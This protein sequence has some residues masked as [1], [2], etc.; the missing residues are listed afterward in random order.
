MKMTKRFIGFARVSSREQERE[1]FSLDVQEEAFEFFAKREKGVVDKVFRIAETATKTEQRKIFR[2]AIEFAKTNAA[3]YDGMLFYKIDRAARNIKDLILLEDIEEKYGLPFISVTQ[4]VENTPTGRMIRRTLATMGA[5]QTEQQ[6][7]D[8][9]SGIAKRV[10]LGWFPSRCPY[11]YRNVRHDDRATAEVHPENALKVRRAFELRAYEGMLVEQIIERLYEDGLFYAE[12]KPR[13]PETK[14]YAILHDLSY[15]GFVR[16]QGKW[17]P[18]L[19]EP[20]IDKLTWDLVRVSFGEQRYRSHELVYANLLIRCGYCGHPITGEE[21]A[22]ETKTGTKKYRYYR[23]ARYQCPGHPRI[24]VRESELDTQVRQSLGKFKAE[25]LEWQQLMLSIA[26]FRLDHERANSEIKAEE[27]KR[28]LSLIEGQRDELLNL[29]LAKVIAEDKFNA[30]QGEL[31]EREALIRHQVQIVDEQRN[32]DN[33]LAERAPGVFEQIRQDWDALRF[34]A[35]QDILRLLFGG[36]LLDG[37]TL[38]PDNE[39]PFELFSATQPSA[40][41]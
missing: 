38:V 37:R 33:A 10:A 36:F 32:R 6:S 17:H 3:K 8:I 12:S 24:R 16:Y 9:R 31:L 15:L 11:G 25:N 22:K 14:M 4:P 23:C 13:F 18:G 35:K 20:L 26:V 39:T 40:V 28:Q 19:H 41:A 7:L 21:K 2:E 34:S 1:G 29:R 30:K 5:F 27:V